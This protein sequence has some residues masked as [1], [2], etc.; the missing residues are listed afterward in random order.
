ML[1]RPSHPAPTSVT[2]AR[3][4]VGRDGGSCRVD[5]GCWRSRIFF[6]KGLDYPNHVDREREFRVCA[7]GPHGAMGRYSRGSRLCGAAPKARRTASGTRSAVPLLI[8][9]SAAQKSCGWSEAT[10]G[11]FAV[12]GICPVGV[13]SDPSR[14]SNARPRNDQHTPRRARQ[15]ERCTHQV[16]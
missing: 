13:I 12:C 5:L 4:S 8:G 15:N 16:H 6:R 14:R 1:P 10:F 3:P 11:T 2:C 7:H 9:F